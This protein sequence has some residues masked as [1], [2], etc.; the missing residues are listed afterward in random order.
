MKITKSQLKYL[1]KEELH[2]LLSEEESWFTPPE[3]PRLW[4]PHWKKMGAHEE[5][6]MKLPPGQ[7]APE[8]MK[9]ATE[10]WFEYLDHGPKGMSDVNRNNWIDLKMGI[11]LPPSALYNEEEWG[12]VED[13]LLRLNKDPKGTTFNKKEIEDYNNLINRRNKF[14]EPTRPAPYIL[15]PGDPLVPNPNPRQQ[16][17]LAENSD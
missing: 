9:K 13:Y 11:H 5:P 17:G 8:D 4:V 7:L 14:K 1:I 15:P 3:M 10:A 16:Y 12:R 2:K 6:I